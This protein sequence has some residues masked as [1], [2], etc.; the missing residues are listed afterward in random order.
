MKSRHASVL[1]LL[2]AALVFPGSARPPAAEKVDLDAV[3]RI[4][5]EG[6]A[7]ST[8][9][10]IESYLTDVYGPR[11][12][13]SPNIN[14][15]AEWAQQ[16]DERVGPDGRPSGELLVRTRLAES[17]LSRRR[18]RTARVSARSAIPKPGP[19]AHRAGHCRGGAGDRGGGARF[20]H[21]ARK[22][23][24]QVRAD[25]RRASGART[26]QAAGLAFDRSRSAGDREAAA[27]VTEAATTTP[28]GRPAGISEET[29]AVLRRRGCRG[30]DRAEP[31]RRR[32][33]LCRPGG[34]VGQPRSKGPAAAAADRP[35]GRALRPDRPDTG[36][37]DPVTLRWTSTTGSTTTTRRPS[38]SSARFPA[39]TRP[40]RS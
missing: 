10:E 8:V 3:S 1:L 19:R 36:K 25:R 24:R 30:A 23:A 14:E 16:A 38:T 7:R 34:A 33:H 9:M 18:R 39:P 35:G 26:V 11:L 22:A 37:T 27:R 21:L 20:R 4:K 13:G 6:L 31:A 2:L 15:A 5:D 28:G 40:T 12:T 17:A 29:A 32:W